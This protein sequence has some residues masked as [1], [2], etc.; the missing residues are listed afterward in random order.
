M[1]ANYLRGA[2]MPKYGPTLYVGVGIPIPILNQE[3][4]K[5][6]GISDQE[7][8]CNL[9]DYGVLRRNRPKIMETNYH[10]LKSGKIEIEGKEV[11]TSPLSSYKK[12][13][14]VAEELKNWIVNGDFLLS[15]PVD[16]I[17]FKGCTV[18]P[19][20]IRRPSILVRDLKKKPTITAKPE[21]AISEVAKMLVDNNINH[22]PVVDHGGR[23]MG[24]V[25]SWDIAHAV[26]QGSKS[27]TDVMTKK[28][29]VAMEDEPVEV[30]ARRIDKHDISGV[31]I[32][33]RENRVKGMITAEDISRLICSQNNRV[34]GSQ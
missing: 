8:A 31:P 12:A 18:K 25:T 4:A 32:I 1:D 10:E 30:I 27:L 6:T 20:Q 29:V 23:L 14:E 9:I 28:V 13:L 22:L 2:T 24:I 34:G 21:E 11:Q 3:I 7:I 26:A 17:P 16:H 5:H 33:D 15:K 19:L